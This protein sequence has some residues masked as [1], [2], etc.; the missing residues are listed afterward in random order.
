M[1][2]S[3]YGINTLD[4]TNISFAVRADNDAHIALSHVH[5]NWLVDSYEIVIGGWTNQKSAIR[6]CDQCVPKVQVFHAPQLI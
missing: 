3:D 6:K 4:Q 1:Y 5:G 2:L